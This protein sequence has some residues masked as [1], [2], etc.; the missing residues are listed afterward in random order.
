MH[1]LHHTLERLAA[2]TVCAAL[3]AA[4]ASAQDVTLDPV[5]R[6]TYTL[7]T[8]NGTEFSIVQPYNN[9]FINSY[10]T[11]FDPATADNQNIR[12]LFVYDLPAAP[13]GQV[14]AAATLRLN[15]PG[16][17]IDGVTGG[18]HEVTIHRVDATI[19][20]LEAS[21]ASFSDLGAGAPY[22]GPV[23]L[24]DADEGTF[25]DFPLDAGGLAALNAALG[26]Q[27]ALSSRSD[28]EDALDIKRV[29]FQQSGELGNL[30]DGNSQL[31][32]TWGTVSTGC[33]F[34]LIAD[35][36][37]PA[38][39]VKVGTVSVDYDPSSMLW[40]VT[41]ETTG[42]WWI[43]GSHLDVACDPALFPMNKRGNPL[44]GRFAYASST[45]GQSV[46]YIVPDEMCGAGMPVYFAAHAVVTDVSTG[47]VETAWADGTT[48]PGNNW[49]T[50]AE[51]TLP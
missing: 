8:S 27:W 43:R 37:S 21:A 20:E 34:D 5:A 17:G 36:G 24:T 47:R 31:L 4:S 33:T 45:P 1:R 11:G 22:A 9:A 41:Y 40:T 25:V 29:A 48:S 46:V 10:V 13:P 7:R 12:G 16:G 19:A 39:A 28:R 44:V 23:T 51:C 14:A 38:T 32:I 35:G 6:G 2:L 3:G 18:P 50:Y 30:A 49:A 15:V 42:S 26:G